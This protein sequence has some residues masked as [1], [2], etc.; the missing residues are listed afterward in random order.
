MFIF[1]L[2]KQKAFLIIYLTFCL[3][4][5]VKITKHMVLCIY[6]DN[7]KEQFCTNF[8]IHYHFILPRFPHLTLNYLISSFKVTL[9]YQN[10]T[11][12]DLEN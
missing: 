6:K 10:H 8:T 11:M 2:K 3:V 7:F 9:A 1:N 4:Y 5:L 12:S